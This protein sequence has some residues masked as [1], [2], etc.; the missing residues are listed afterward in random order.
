MLKEKK[1]ELSEILIETE[2]EEKQLKQLVL[3]LEELVEPRL[4]TAYQRIKKSSK[5]GLVVVPIQR[6]ASIGSY[7]LIPPQ[8]Q[9]EVAG[10]NK[11][12]IDE[13]SGRILID[14]ELAQEQE[15]YI[16]E[17]IKNLDTII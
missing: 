3:K 4:L 7:I 8:R 6:N 5:N 2:A 17:I 10:R 15:Q 12:I 9:I 13:H 14:T 16:E 1:K 11:I